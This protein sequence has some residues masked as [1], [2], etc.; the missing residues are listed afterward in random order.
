MKNV[1]IVYFNREDWLIIEHIRKNL[2]S[3]FG[4]DLQ[5]ENVFL[6]ELDENEI[7]QSDLFLVLYD[8][9]IHSLSRHIQNLNNVV[10]ITRGINR[11]KIEELKNIKTMTKML[12]VNDAD[13]STLQ[14]T[15]ILQGLGF[16]HITF[17]PYNK[18]LDKD[19]FYDHIRVAI[20]TSAVTYVPS[21]I[22][23]TINIGY[24]E[25]GYTT[26]ISIMHKLKIDSDTVYR[27]ILKRV[28]DIVETGREVETN[29]LISSYLKSE[30][31]DRVIANSPEGVLLSDSGY[32]LVY[33]NLSANEI[34][35]I[36]ENHLTHNLKDL[37]N[38][39]VFDT[40]FSKSSKKHI[41]IHDENYLIEKTPIKIMELNIGY[42]IFLYKEKA[43]RDLEI[44]LKNILV[45]KGQYAKYSFEDILCRSQ[46]M[47]RCIQQAKKV[48]LTD[49]TI[50]IEGESGTGK[51]LLAQS[52][53]NYSSR[54]EGPFVAVNCAALPETLLESE[55][56]GYEEG[57]FT[58]AKKNGKLGLFEQANTGTI[59]LDEIGD[60]SANLQRQ[61]LRVL[62]ERQIMRV[63][64]D[65]LIDIDVR[66]VVAT[67]KLLLS[68]VDK[69]RF[70]RDLYY[71]LS[72]I[73]IQIPPLKERKEDI[74]TILAK[75]L[76]IPLE[77]L[78]ATE[79]KN[80][81]DYD[82]PGN[83]REL[84]S[85]ASYYNT[86]GEFPPHVQSV[87]NGFEVLAGDIHDMV[88]EVVAENTK[89]F[90]GI[91]RSAILSLLRERSIHI[92]D[93]RLRG[94]LSSLKKKGMIEINKGRSGTR[95]SPEGVSYLKKQEVV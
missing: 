16:D 89:P 80:I 78:S 95:V 21:F 37:L 71:R 70:R 93:G 2:E 27:N 9:Y 41:E 39:N 63:G 92:G 61:L 82:W 45:E 84:E 52:I 13:L 94:I 73:P 5:F 12:V 4:D 86:L 23:K 69:G 32:N 68:E 33:S 58:G 62:Q 11:K 76:T 28:H 18:S 35:E 20:T 22:N 85:A 42:C 30:M 77:K 53:H 44:E 34:F 49:H 79:K 64:S 14:T 24:R 54:R 90:S 19:S 60:I 46:S 50:L 8:D 1:S 36:E 31:L 17:V 75:R 48:A 51:E 59:F 91:G 74:Q 3:V 40:I 47:K 10:T 55:L 38:K 66:I 6:D 88:L 81:L 56:F 87:Q 57:A 26:L 65:R 25:V 83:V 43:I 29:D 15:Y 7:L 72:V 67:N